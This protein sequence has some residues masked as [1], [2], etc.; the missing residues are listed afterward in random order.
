MPERGAMLM[1]EQSN[2]VNT[3]CLKKARDTRTLPVQ[4]QN[5]YTWREQSHDAL[6]TRCNSPHEHN[7]ADALYCQHGN[8]TEFG[9]GVVHVCP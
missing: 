5:T 3:P 7:T 4:V 6:P 9:P 1:L 8:T 2:Y